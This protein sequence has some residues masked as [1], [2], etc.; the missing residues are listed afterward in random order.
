MSEGI[1][2]PLGALVIAVVVVV[3]MVTVNSDPPSASG[4]DPSCNSIAAIGCAALA[5]V[6]SVLDNPDAYAAAHP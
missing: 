4:R 6:G 3:G 2:G 5:G 1:S